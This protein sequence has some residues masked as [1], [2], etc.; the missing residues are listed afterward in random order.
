MIDMKMRLPRRHAN[1]TYSFSHPPHV[2][3]RI[4]AH[5]V[6]AYGAVRPVAVHLHMHDHGVGARW[7]HRRGGGAGAGA[8]AG[9]AAG[10]GAGAGGSRSRAGTFVDNFGHIPLGSYGGYGVAESWWPLQGEGANRS[11]VNSWPW[12]GGG[13]GGGGA[14]GAAGAAG[15]VG[16]GSMRGG[17]LGGNGSG[18]D[19]GERRP[20][21]FVAPAPDGGGAALRIV[22]GDT[23]TAHCTYDTLHP[24]LYSP[25]PPPGKRY[26]T[27]YVAYGIELGEE[28]CGFLMLFCPHDSSKRFEWGTLV[29]DDPNTD[30]IRPPFGQ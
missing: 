27:P 25:A 9:A 14:A 18:V 17:G 16:A 28:M 11:A 7:E 21:R 12:K 1:Y 3:D 8:G 4:L 6:Q 13:G 5:D 19:G 24:T 2:L 26:T 30:I 23:L 22:K 10:A 29:G 20:F 15:A